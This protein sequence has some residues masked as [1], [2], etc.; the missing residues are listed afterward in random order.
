VEIANKE[1][2]VKL[3][4]EVHQNIWQ[5]WFKTQCWQQASQNLIL[6][7][8]YCSTTQIDKSK[9]TKKEVTIAK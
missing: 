4:R 7:I 5:K 6:K 3:N 9:Q 2:A 1:L 8:L